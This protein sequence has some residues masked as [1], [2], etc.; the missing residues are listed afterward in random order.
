MKGEQG[1]PPVANGMRGVLTTDLRPKLIEDTH[2]EFENER[3]KA[4]RESETQ[5]VGEVEF[6]EDDIR[7]Y[8]YEMFGPQFNREKT[9]SSPEELA[10]ETGI[11]SFSMAGALFDFGWAMT[12]HKCVDPNTLV[13]TPDGLVRAGQLPPSGRI[14]T[15]TGWAMYRNFVRN[16]RGAM[17]ELHTADGYALR[18]TP[19][20]GVDVWDPS[21]GY[22]RRE[23]NQIRPGDILRLR[24]GAEFVRGTTT[25]LP[26]G[27]PQDVRAKKY[28]LP[29]S[30]TADVAEFFGLMVADGTVWAR[31]FR[32]AK[33]HKDVADRFATLCR[34][35]FGKAPSRF[36]KLGA[37]HVEINSA[38]IADW[39]RDVG[40]MT[41]NSKNV[42]D[43]ILASPLGV[44]AR[45]LRGLFEDGTVNMKNGLLDHIE[46][47]S[48][49]PEV[50]RTVR[51]ML[52]R[53]GIVS[54]STDHRQSSVYIYGA[55]A[56][57]FGARIGFV[58]K[59]KQSRL[60]TRAPIG[61]RYTIPLLDEEEHLAPQSERLAI[62]RHRAP[63]SVLADRGGFHHS[64]VKSVSKYTGES[65]CVEVPDGH[66]F[67]Q[68]G[69]CGWNCQGSGVDDFLAVVERPGPVDDDTWKRWQ[70][71]I[72]T[73]AVKKLTVLK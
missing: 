59:F 30:C 9:Y 50:R 53:F 45:F 11:H 51:T 67:L 32:L 28:K 10:R 21:A 4:A 65:C 33:R 38:L 24:L 46:F 40:G 70:Y 64:T 54:G 18:A 57:T 16:R 41:P 8:T 17:L 72:C 69:F 6:P 49:V 47:S 19:D 12:A 39:L 36:F 71:T 43:C 7:A 25:R 73:R 48:T 29:K 5:F 61:T 26:N 56:K 23:A 13:E 62:Q 68:D 3:G 35:L 58:S 34:K 44:Q 52:L 22:V 60:K 14:A 55:Y 66:Q 37:H 1:R 31:G 27:R 15:P 20:H 2:G 63:K 42:P